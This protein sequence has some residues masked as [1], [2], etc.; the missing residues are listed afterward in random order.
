MNR[1]CLLLVL[2]CVG[3]AGC[4]APGGD[5]VVVTP[6]DKPAPSATA[7]APIDRWDA[8]RPTK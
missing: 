6:Q 2:G 1:S 7:E 3:L 8:L 4:T 5:A